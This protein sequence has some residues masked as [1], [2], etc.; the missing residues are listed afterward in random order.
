VQMADAGRRLFRRWVENA[1][2]KLKSAAERTSK[3]PG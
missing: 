1:L 3:A 2:E